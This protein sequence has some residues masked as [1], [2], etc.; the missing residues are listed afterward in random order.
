M[1][2]QLKSHSCSVQAVISKQR[3]Q[4]W[5]TLFGDFALCQ[6]GINGFTGAADETGYL[7]CELASACGRGDGQVDWNRRRRMVLPQ[8][9]LDLPF[10]LVQLPQDF[11]LA[12]FKLRDAA[13]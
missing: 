5:R 4:Q 10:E 11:V 9:G 7:S 2:P 12:C 8:D 1:R 6:S 3:P 13:Y